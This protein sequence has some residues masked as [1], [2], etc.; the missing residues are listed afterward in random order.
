MDVSLDCYRAAIGFFGGNYSRPKRRSNI[1][2][3]I[4]ILAL[5]YISNLIFSLL[6]W[7]PEG[8]MVILLHNSCLSCSK[9]HISPSNTKTFFVLTLLYIFSLINRLL[10]VIAG[11]ETNPCQSTLPRFPFATWNLDSLLARDG[12][13]LSSIEESIAYT[14]LI[15]LGLLNLIWINK[16]LTRKLNCHAMPLT[17]SWKS[18]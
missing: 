9:L 5:H 7:Y 6:F 14:I 15:F 17:P 16:F 11:V 18:H 3:N 4:I 1:S 12:C 8:I 10:L 2:I 13:K